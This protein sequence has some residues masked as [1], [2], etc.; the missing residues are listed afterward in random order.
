[1]LVRKWM[2]EFWMMMLFV[3]IGV[4]TAMSEDNGSDTSCAGAMSKS[5]LAEMQGDIPSPLGCDTNSLK[6]VQVALAFGMAITILV[7]SGSVCS[8]GHVNCAVTTA[9]MVS[10]NCGI[11]EGVGIIIA[12]FAGSLVG[13]ALLAASIPER[14]DRTGENFG[15]NFVQQYHFNDGS[16]HKFSDGNAFCGEFFFTSLLLFVVYHCCVAQHKGAAKPWG[17]MSK[18]FAPLAVGMAVFCAHCVLIPIT[19]CSINP[20][21]SF[22][23]L[24]VGEIRGLPSDNKAWDDLWIFIIAPELAAVVAGLAYRFVPCGAKNTADLAEEEAQEQEAV[25][26]G[27]AIGGSA[28]LP[29]ATMQANQQNELNDSVNVTVAKSQEDAKAQPPQDLRQSYLPPAT[30][31][32]QAPDVV[33]VSF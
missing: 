12:Q 16:T 6:N 11:L 25:G 26:G 3:M 21:R 27:K 14:L 31:A 30:A 24:V 10:G 20:T 29:V 22:G 8:G 9:L 18:N 7:Y 1:M 15:T 2:L 28:P 13:A 23:P 17:N 19:G 5:S 4:G 32:A 33:P